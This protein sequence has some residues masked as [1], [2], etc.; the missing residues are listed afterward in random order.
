MAIKVG[1]RMEGLAELRAALGA[2]AAELDAGIDNAINATGLEIR[3]EIIRQYNSG[4]AS[5]RVYQKYNPRRTHQASAPGQAPMT[6]TGRLA[7]ETAFRRVGP[8]TVE[9]ANRLQ[10]AAAL[11]YGTATIRPRPVW[12]QVALEAEPKLKRRLETTVAAFTR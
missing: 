2:G 8:L 11:E 7:N 3:T 4:P 10:Y 12:R 5:G 9:V 6:D 1:A